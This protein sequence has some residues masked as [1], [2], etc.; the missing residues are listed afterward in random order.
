MYA[1]DNLW[2][3][4]R[5]RSNDPFVILREPF[6]DMLQSMNRL[7]FAMDRDELDSKTDSGL[8]TIQH[9]IGKQINAVPK[10]QTR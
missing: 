4:N 7:L 6:D 2:E 10:F 1:E 9:V 5:T 3:S 8:N